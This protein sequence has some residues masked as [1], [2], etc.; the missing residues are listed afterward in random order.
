MTLAYSG[1]FDYDI[2]GRYVKNDG[3]YVDKINGDHSGMLLWERVRP[4][5]SMFELGAGICLGSVE[6]VARFAFLQAGVMIFNKYLVFARGSNTWSRLGEERLWGAAIGAEL[7]VHR[8]MIFIRA[9]VG[10][11]DYETVDRYGDPAKVVVSAMVN[12]SP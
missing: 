8:D 11:R 4:A 5:K 3:L 7:P 6:D 2:T 9:K 12:I 10:F 1:R